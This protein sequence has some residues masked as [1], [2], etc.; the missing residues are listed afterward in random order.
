ML[1]DDLCSWSHH[2]GLADT[3]WWVLFKGLGSKVWRGGSTSSSHIYVCIYI[4][5]YLHI[6]ESKGKDY[7]SVTAR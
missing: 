7:E 6:G 5:I 2:A 3:R 4:Y 1:E